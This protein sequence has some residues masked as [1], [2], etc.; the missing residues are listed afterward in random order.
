MDTDSF[1]KKTA[2]EAGDAVWKRFGKDG[3]LY[4]K[5]EY[6]YDVVTK[7]DLMADKFIVSKIKKHFPTHGINAEESGKVHEGAEYVW[8]IDPIDGTKNFSHN[9][10]L[11]GTMIALAH[12]KRVILS[13]VYIP[14]NKELFFAKAGKGA[15]LNGKRI[16]CST[17]KDFK[18]T[19]GFAQ[20]Q[21]MSR[22]IGFLKNILKLK[23]I[24]HLGTATYNC[25][26]VNG[27]YV[28]AGRKDWTVAPYGQV[29][30]FAAPSLILKE[31]GCKVTN[32]DG[33]PWTLGTEGLVAA[34]PYLHR[35]L[36]KL[37]RG[38]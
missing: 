26:A 37:T 16:H 31:S 2:Q 38:V 21:F 4:M 19:E 30:D 11:F 17:K 35:Q 34:N 1:I 23:G 10:P 20:M 25:I 12:K 7:A 18:K 13:A 32:L 9:I 24:D 14:V 29:H 22:N 28:A 15:Y 6:A 8:H 33:K 36:I 27:C 3:P 5:S